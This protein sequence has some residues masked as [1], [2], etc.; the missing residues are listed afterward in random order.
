METNDKTYVENFEGKS[1]NATCYL[2]GEVFPVFG[3]FR[4]YC[5]GHKDVFPWHAKKHTNLFLA[6][7]FRLPSSV[8]DKQKLTKFLLEEVGLKKNSE[9][10]IDAYGRFSKILPM[11]E[12]TYENL[13]DT[14]HGI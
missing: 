1:Y 6:D 8:N 14:S 11:G 7:D 10:Y 9:G 12:R 2:S 3:Q 13:Q 4:Y 5:Q